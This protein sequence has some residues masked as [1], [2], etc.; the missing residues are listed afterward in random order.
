MNKD[1]IYLKLILSPVNVQKILNYEISIEKI[2]GMFF[3][4][5]DYLE[6]DKK[7]II[8]QLSNELVPILMS[9][10]KLKIWYEGIKRKRDSKIIFK[11]VKNENCKEEEYTNLSGKMVIKELQNKNIPFLLDIDRYYFEKKCNHLNCNE[12]FCKAF[13]KI[14]TTQLSENFFKDKIVDNK[15]KWIFFKESLDVQ[16]I[17]NFLILIGTFYNLRKEEIQKLNSVYFDD[18]FI[19]EIKKESSNT[20]KKILIS[21]ARSIFFPAISSKDRNSMSIDYHRNSSYPQEGNKSI[22]RLDCINENKSGNGNSGVERIIFISEM[23]GKIEERRYIAYTPNHDIER[24]VL[25][26]RI[27]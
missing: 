11:D 22:Y 27:I 21:I 4:M 14:E 13:N 26:A 5:Q 25:R 2:S 20:I 9:E 23:K 7:S 18:E 19:S 8:L 3:L 16:S 12:E 15:E 24:G 10:K 17:R 1:S 6:K